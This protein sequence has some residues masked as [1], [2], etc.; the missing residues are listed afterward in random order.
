MRRLTRVGAE[1]VGGAV[2]AVAVEFLGAE[3]VDAPESEATPPPP[4]IATT[5]QSVGPP[6]I[7]FQSSAL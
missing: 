6:G 2:G 3:E 4:P 5:E 1:E 7:A